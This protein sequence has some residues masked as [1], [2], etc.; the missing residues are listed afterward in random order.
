MSMLGCGVGDI[1]TIYTLAFKVYMAYRDAPGEYR[2]ISDEVKSL[3]IIVGKATGYLE[4]T[5]LSTNN[6][7]EGLEILSGCQHVLE[8]LNSLIENYKSL[9]ST[10]W[11]VFKRVKLGREDIATLRQRLTSNIVLLSNFVTR[12]VI[13]GISLQQ[14]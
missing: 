10:K 6:R 5:A 13:P 9:V 8:D 4:S 3:Q 2:N 11:L 7:Q 14:S 1:I 12:F